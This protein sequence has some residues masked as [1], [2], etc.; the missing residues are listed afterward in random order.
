MQCAYKHVYINGDDD[1][2]T[3]ASEAYNLISR[4]NFLDGLRHIGYAIAPL[5]SDDISEDY[6]CT[7][8][9]T[10]SKALVKLFSPVTK[11]YTLISGRDSQDL[12]SILSHSN[13]IDVKVTGLEYHRFIL[14]K[15]DDL[16]HLCTSYSGKYTLKITPI[17]AYNLLANMSARTYNFVF[18]TSI[19]KVGY[20]T[21]ILSAGR[22]PPNYQERL[23]FYLSKKM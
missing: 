19:D 1:I 14:I 18:D 2:K 3:D 5:V 15:I 17:H 23:L 16:W 22:Y 13:F 21:L 12:R 11:T 8:C 6:N 10:T 4:G 20:A 7:D 9:I